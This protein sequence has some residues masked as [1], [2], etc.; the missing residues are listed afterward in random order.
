MGPAI[1]L[2]VTLF[3]EKESEAREEAVSTFTKLA[4]HGMLKVYIITTRLIRTYS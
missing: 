1:P 2:L 4:E 3:T